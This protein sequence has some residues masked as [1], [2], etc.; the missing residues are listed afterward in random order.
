METIKTLYNLLQINHK[1]EDVPIRYLYLK[2]VWGL[3]QTLIGELE[4]MSQSYVSKVI[5]NARKNIPRETYESAI[6]DLFSP[7]EIQYIHMLPREILPDIP[8][9]AF[10]NNLLGV[11]P[12]HPFFDYIETTINARIAGL[13]WLGVMNKRIVE[14]FDKNQPTVSMI[15]K[16]QTDRIIKMERPNRYDKVTHYRLHEHIKP[17]TKFIKAGGQN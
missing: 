17:Y 12:I 6:S 9:I 10:I 8:A 1:I 13:A 15:V 11:Y 7:E 4:G 14:I 5:M 3:E 16:R 2:D